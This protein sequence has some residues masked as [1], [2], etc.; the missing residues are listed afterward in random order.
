MRALSLAI[1]VATLAA[2]APA[3]AQVVD[4]STITCKQFFEGP[5]TRISYVLTWLDAY[6]RD[7]D[8][9]PVMDFDKMKSDVTKLGAYCAQNPTIGLITAAD[10]VFGG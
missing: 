4:L 3:R 7:E 8:A 6:Y 1:L 2:A 5:E 9:P 10:K